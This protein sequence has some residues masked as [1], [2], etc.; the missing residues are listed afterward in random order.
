[1][2]FT[3]IINIKLFNEV[4]QLHQKHMQLPVSKLEVRDSGTII[5]NEITNPQM[6]EDTLKLPYL[7]LTSLSL[8]YFNI[9]THCL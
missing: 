7:Y 4:K 6:D 3:H 9:F 1:M 5:T 8:G 2:A